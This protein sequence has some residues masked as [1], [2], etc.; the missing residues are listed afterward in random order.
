[1]SM[2]LPERLAALP[3]DQW[4]TSPP[5]TAAALTAL[6]SKFAF[7]LPDD[8]RR[9]MLTTNGCGLYGHATQLNLEPPDELLWHNDDPRF[10]AGLPAMLVIGDDNGDAL[11][12]YDPTNHLGKGAWAIYMVDFALI[13]FPHSKFAAAGL[14]ALLEK[15]LAGEAIWEYPYLGPLEHPDRA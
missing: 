15:I 2:T 8:Y 12:Y 3:Q 4:M 11:F 13:D 9:L 1:M 7:Q 6:E 5:A 14:T 10:V